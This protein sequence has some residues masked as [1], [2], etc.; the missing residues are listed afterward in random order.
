MV[1]V[2]RAPSMGRDNS[3]DGQDTKQIGIAL[4]A[5]ESEKCECFIFHC[6]MVGLQFLQLIYTAIHDHFVGDS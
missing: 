2:T 6:G 3:D 4:L 1:Y 5:I